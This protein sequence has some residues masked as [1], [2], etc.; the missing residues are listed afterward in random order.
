MPTYVRAQ[1][2]WRAYVTCLAATPV[3][4]TATCGPGP[5]L[6]TAPDPGRRAPGYARA[7]RLAEIHSQGPGQSLV[8]LAWEEITN[9]CVLIVRKRECEET[10]AVADV[11]QSSRQ[12]CR[13]LISSPF[14]KQF[15]ALSL[16]SVIILLSGTG[17]N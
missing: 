13:R 16:A 6:R 12:N 9:T 17:E 2:A 8:D 15:S 11:K 3:A 10:S 4:A 1:R 5:A 7:R 14:T